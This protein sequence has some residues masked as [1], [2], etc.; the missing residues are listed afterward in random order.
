MS[1][2]SDDTSKDPTKSPST[3]CAL[4]GQDR[5]VSIWVTRFSEPLCVAADIFDNS[6][7]DISWYILKG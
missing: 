3:I 4:G 6:I 5:S 1:D 2:D 7:Y